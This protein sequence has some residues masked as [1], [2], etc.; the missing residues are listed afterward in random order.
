MRITKRI[1]A[2]VLAVATASALVLTPATTSYPFAPQAQAQEQD[3]DQ[4]P[5]AT[6]VSKTVDTMAPAT[7]VWG[8]K[9]DTDLT[10]LRHVDVSYPENVEVGESFEV[11]IQPGQMVS[12]R[13]EVGRI[14]YDIALPQNVTI[15]DMSVSEGFGFG[16]IGKNSTAV[17]SI[18]R[19]DE[20]GNPSPTGQY[21]RISA[22][23]NATVNNGPGA[24]NDDPKAGLSVPKNTTFRLPKVTFKVTA[25]EETGTVVFGL[26]GAGAPAGPKGDENTNNTL[27][28][29]EDGV[30]SNDAVFVNA[31]PAGAELVK[32][33]VVKTDIVSQIT[34][35]KADLA[36]SEPNENGK[37]SVDLEARA[38]RQ[39][40]DSGLP[41][42]AAVQFQFRTAEGEWTDVG[43]PVAVDGKHARTNVEIDDKDGEVFF[44]AVQQE[45]TAADGYKV[46]SAKSNEKSVDVKAENKTT[47]ALGEVPPSVEPGTEVP[48][49]AT[50]TVEGR[51]L[52]DGTKPVVVFKADGEE[53]G[54]AEVGEDGKA[55]L[56]HKFETQS[57]KPI[58]LTAEVAEI[59]NEQ[60]GNRSWPAAKSEPKT[61]S[62]KTNQRESTTTITSPAEGTK[63][64][65]GFQDII[66]R[67]E[68][69]EGKPVGEDGKVEFWVYNEDFPD[70]L[71]M[72]EGDNN[73]DGTFTISRPFAPGESRLE[74]RFLGSNTALPS[75]SPQVTVTA[76]EVHITISDKSDT[77]WDKDTKAD[78]T[79]G[80][81][82]EL[83]VTVTHSDVQSA[84]KQPVKTGKVEFYIGEEKIGEQTLSDADNGVAAIKYDFAGKSG[85]Q[86]VVAKY[87]G[88]KN[89]Q[90]KAGIEASEANFTFNL[91]E[92]VRETKTTVSAEWTD[93]TAVEGDNP[94]TIKATIVDA[95]GNP[96]PKGVT[97]EF[98]DGDKAIGTATTNDEGIATL[99][100]A[101]LSNEDH[102]VK[103]VV[104]KQKIEG[105]EFGASEGSAELKK[106]EVK[107]TDPEEP[108]ETPEKPGE[109]SNKDSDG[110]GL[111]DKQEEELGTD[112]NKAD[113][114]G[115]GILDGDEVNGNPKTDPK[116]PDT[117]GDGINDKDDSD[118]LNPKTPTDED[119]P[120]EDPE[121]PDEDS[122]KDSDGDGLTDKQ[123]EEL[124]TDPNKADTD[125]DGFSDGEEVKEKTDPKDSND[126]PGAQTPSPE[127]EQP[128][129]DSDGDGLTDKQEQEL[130]TDPNKADTDGDGFSDGEEVKEKTDPTD[131]KSKPLTTVEVITPSS[132]DPTDC[133][134]KPWLKVEKK[135]G[136]K[137]TITVDGKEVQPNSDGVVNYEFGQTAK[138]V[139]AP[140]DGYRFPTG[141][142][143]EWSWTHELPS[144]CEV[145]DKPGKPSEP[146]KP[147]DAKPDKPSKPGKP[148]EPSKPGDAKPDK[149]SK[150]GKPSEPSK[151]G[152]S[153]GSSNDSKPGN[154][155]KSASPSKTG[156]SGNSNSS[157]KSEAAAKSS[158]SASNQA[159]SSSLASTGVQALGAIAGLAA[160]AIVIGGA[161]IFWRRRNQDDQ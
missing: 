32:V 99:P 37:L 22:P 38:T 133:D 143:T 111:T 53:I 100:D 14:K 28:F 19:V 29:A 109:D 78:V 98:Y 108:G 5:A 151:P 40:D 95:D 48:L 46:L 34:L 116:N 130:G 11:T 17:Y 137:Y 93:E 41:R 152:A 122:N 31:G 160:L 4:A 8:G 113:T 71:N 123:E 119:G 24:H 52:P 61:I 83:K 124:G 42:G 88:V 50:Y 110:D 13:E 39:K 115:D 127:P 25:P 159:G 85:E 139:A 60:S 75:T 7:T 121:Q 54:K 134:T 148:S 97:V 128:N 26:R 20:V 63:M 79:V 12:G 154:G 9:L 153:S 136:V 33:N 74:A 135:K 126:H 16:P 64:G 3:K 125:G 155:S 106:R 138:V 66:A 84:N 73:G 55:T 62:I 27:S 2:T 76:D 149:P 59:V 89:A 112:P 23:S 68:V 21:A 140:E 131:P 150:P 92:Q 157:S 87:L 57:E 77:T 94:A 103:A 147:G 51:Q 6:K 18:Q 47:V 80:E 30:W 141:A 129:K 10:N 44:R 67:V 69:A 49:E 132:F 90:N 86:V 81:E 45:Y 56:T 43:E 65:T 158:S 104:G 118:P 15:T 142:K 82:T 102:T 114:D 161:L 70:G 35:D 91:T 96:V 36:S 156:T 1:P 105:K 117:D 58:Q 101:K 72:G 107:P 145:P 144:N 120:G 146:S